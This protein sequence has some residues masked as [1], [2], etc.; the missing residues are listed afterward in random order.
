MSWPLTI[1]FITGRKYGIQS[2]KYQILFLNSN[3]SLRILYAYNSS[4]IPPLR[5]IK[6]WRYM[7]ISGNIFF[8][9]FV[10]LFLIMTSVP[11]NYIIQ[12]SEWNCWKIPL[13]NTYFSSGEGP[14][15]SW[16]Y[17]QGQVIWGQFSHIPVL[18]PE[19]YN[20]HIQKLS[21]NSRTFLLGLCIQILLT[22]SII[23]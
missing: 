16:C 11:T 2:L 10:N 4:H 5:I 8:F 21:T 15:F 17:W 19:P 9:P 6:S 18:R 13:V 12:P 20:Q 23:S 7:I 22:L 3:I 1:T 14:P